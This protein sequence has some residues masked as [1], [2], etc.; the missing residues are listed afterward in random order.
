[1]VSA[2]PSGGQEKDKPMR[3]RLLFLVMLTGSLMAC[4]GSD[5]SPSAPAADPPLDTGSGA[6]AGGVPADDSMDDDPVA[7]TDG[8]LTELVSGLRTP[9]DLMFGPAGSE[10]DDELF[11]V[12][13]EGVEAT[14]VQDVDSTPVQRRFENSL[15]GAMAVDLDTGGNFYFACLTPVMGANIG[16]V[17]V[18]TINSRVVDFQY[19]GIDGPVG[20][21]LDAAGGLF[22]FNRV[23]GTVVRIDFG[24]GAGPDQH[25]V[26]IIAEN[27]LVTDEVLPAHLFVDASGRLLIAETAANRVLVW[28]DGE[29][30]TY[31]D[32]GLNRPVGIAQL[33]SG[34][35]LVAS[36]G[37]GALVEFDGG[38][39]LVRTIDTE[40]GEN[41]LQSVAVRGD[42]SVFV[43]DDDGGRGGL[44]RVNL[45]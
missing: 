33:P 18:R 9:R 24:D 34:N 44:F 25:G 39:A 27:L 38:G 7:D 43:V 45:P 3:L 30:E 22:V 11:V 14:W 6:D 8:I 41:R 17:T 40:L 20:V 15:V 19:S 21:A 10:L 23:A 35:I 16:V 29:L 26:Q 28:A 13:F 36:Y 1:M 2:L 5:S 32:A 4:G 42:G 37:D 12:H 31:A